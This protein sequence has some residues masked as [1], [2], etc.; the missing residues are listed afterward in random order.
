MTPG[1]RV[2]TSH[3]RAICSKPEGTL[4]QLHQAISS[5]PGQ[6][7]QAMRSGLAAH[8]NHVVS[9]PLNIDD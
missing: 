7:M 8:V 9:L 4:Q 2:V 1:S 6:T 3:I 5:F